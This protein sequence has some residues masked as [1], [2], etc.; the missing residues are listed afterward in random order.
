[1]K[2]TLL[3]LVMAAFVSFAATAQEKEKQGQHHPRKMMKRHRADVAKQLNFSDAQKQQL[4]T[5]NEDFRKKMQ[6]LNS[7]ENITVK[8]MRDRKAA[9]VKDHKTSMQQLLTAEQKTKLEQ[10]KR[11]RKAI[12]EVNAKARL[13]KAKIKLGLSDAQAS[14]LSNLGSSFK[15]KMKS[16]KENESLSRTDKREQIKKLAE[17][18]K[19]EVKKL[20][21]EEQLKKMEEMRRHRKEK[22]A[23]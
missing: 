17:E 2:W 7:N 9:L 16:L 8:E 11:E 14:Q 18:H 22:I 12:H 19:A 13:E 20:L 6:E 10:M 23:R 1:M 3:G 5:I 4:K 21:T 15:S